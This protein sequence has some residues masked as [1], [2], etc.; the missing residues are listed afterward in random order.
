MDKVNRL[1][2]AITFE[3]LKN[4]ENLIWDSWVRGARFIMRIETPDICE[5]DV[6]VTYRPRYC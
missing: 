5:N 2:N 4:S 1:L 6:L 3:I